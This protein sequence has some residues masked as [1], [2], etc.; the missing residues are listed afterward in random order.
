MAGQIIISNIKTDS[1]NTFSILANT[2][3][4]LFSANLASGITTGIPSNSIANTQIISIA[5]TQITGTITAGQLATSLN[6]ATNNVQVAS[7]QSA[8]GTPAITFAANG[9]MTLANTPLQLTGGQIKFPGTQIASSDANTLDD[10]EEGTFTA[11]VICDSGSVT[12]AFNTGSYTKVGRL[13]TVNGYIEM[14]SVSS[15][16]GKMRIAFPFASGSAVQFE[17]TSCFAFNSVVSG[18]ITDFVGVVNSSSSSFDI[19][20]GTGIALS[21]TSA[22]Q[23]KAGTSFRFSATYMTA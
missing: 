18:S 4:V 14:T 15:P 10:Y 2:G 22:N 7:I 8:T 21:A 3:A 17:S 1:D 20:I 5:N 13:V 19:F 11:T 16:S 9:Q 12:Q 6:L 23:M